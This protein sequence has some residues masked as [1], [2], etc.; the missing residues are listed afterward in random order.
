MRQPRAARPPESAGPADFVPVRWGGRLERLDVLGQ[1]IR[2]LFR[3]DVRLGLGNGL[4]GFAASVPV[5]SAGSTEQRRYVSGLLMSGEPVALLGA[6]RT[7]QVWAREEP[8]GWRLTGVAE[9]ARGLEPARALLVTARTPAGPRGGRRTALLVDTATHV[10]GR[11][12]GRPVPRD[13]V[14][15]ELGGAAELWLRSAP[16]THALVAPAAVAAGDTVLRTALRCVR[17]AAGTGRQPDAYG[18]DAVAGAFLD[19]L[20]ADCLGLVAARAVQLLPDNA[21]VYAAAAAAWAP[22]ALTESG[23]D[24]A[25]LLG[26]GLFARTGPCGSFNRQLRGL[27]LPARRYAPVASCRAVLAAQVSA[28]A[29]G[30]W[31][32][33]ENGAP[34]GLYRPGDGLPPLDIR[35][36][37]LAAPSD[38]LAGS[39][40]TLAARAGGEGD[41]AAHPGCAGALSAVLR[42]LVAELREVHRSLAAYRPAVTMAAGPRTYGLTSRYVLLLA[43][44]ACLGVWWHRWRGPHGGF[45]ADS[46]WV[47]A[48]L[49]RIAARLGSVGTGPAP[50]CEHVVRR[51]AYLRFVEGRS[52][53]LYAAPIDGPDVRRSGRE[54]PPDDRGKA[55]L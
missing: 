3:S 51:E 35:P 21:V 20:T 41:V 13:A 24:L 29:Q 2:P 5:W 48:A 31:F 8:Y 11:D 32:A 42:V 25:P 7:E 23:Y 10:P 16:P 27:A 45:L 47:T 18:L 54:R 1:L 40:I 34:P 46:C 9:A 43:A 28:F 12:A 17:D 44:A 55:A 37:P 4:D 15:G 36:Y 22:A 30:P 14:V 6:G 26:A 49:L 33:D 19:L 52:Y 39:L 50:C 38:P 53:D